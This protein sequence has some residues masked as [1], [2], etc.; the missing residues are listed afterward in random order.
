MSVKHTQCIQRVQPILCQGSPIGIMW[1]DQWTI[2]TVDGGRS[3]Q[4]EH[5]VQSPYHTP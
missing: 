1:P 3:A 5:T 4:A 2:S